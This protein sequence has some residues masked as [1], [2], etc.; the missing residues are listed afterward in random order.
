MILE[1]IPRVRDIWWYCKITLQDGCIVC[2]NFDWRRDNLQLLY[3]QCTGGET[4]YNCYLIFSSWTTLWCITNFGHKMFSKT[5]S[6]ITI[7]NSG[8]EPANKNE[9]VYLKRFA[10]IEQQYEL[11]DLEQKQ[12]GHSYGKT[13]LNAFSDLIFQ[14]SS[15]EQKA[16]A[17]HSS[18]GQ[19]SSSMDHICKCWFI[20]DHNLAAS[21]KKKRIS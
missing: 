13:F 1:I 15:S 9:N 8:L 11:G 4:S 14:T 7:V 18:A 19:S 6:K 5:N 12:P 21:V 2:M 16:K 20:K 10:E 3:D 17:S